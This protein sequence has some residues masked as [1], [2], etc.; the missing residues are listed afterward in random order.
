MPPGVLVSSSGGIGSG[1]IGSGANWALPD[2]PPIVGPL[3]TPGIYDFSI[4]C[5]DTF[6]AALQFQISGQPP[7]LLRLATSV[8]ETVQAIATDSISL[9]QTSTTTNA[10]N[11]FDV[12][13]LTWT[14]YNVQADT[15]TLNGPGI[16]LTGDVGSNTMTF[17]RI[18]K[19]ST[20]W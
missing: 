16:A 2:T 18:R 11:N 14:A 10:R 8:N 6:T 3:N 13:R 4:Y 1:L 19:K 12:V 17:S 20:F 15:C 7:S 9:P 5:G